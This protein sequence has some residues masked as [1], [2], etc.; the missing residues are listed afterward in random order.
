MALP[1]K[2][3]PPTSRGKIRAVGLRQDT[4]NLGSITRMGH[5]QDTVR[6]LRRRGWANMA[7]PNKLVPAGTISALSAIAKERLVC[8]AGAE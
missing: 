7:L 2:R 6:S 3:P 1:H 5:R 4:P 8:A